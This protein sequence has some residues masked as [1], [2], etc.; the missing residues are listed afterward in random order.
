MCSGGVGSGQVLGPATTRVGSVRRV[1]CHCQLTPLSTQEPNSIHTRKPYQQMPT[2]SGGYVGQHQPGPLLVGRPYHDQRPLALDRARAR[3]HPTAHPVTAWGRHEL[4]GRE[5]SLAQGV[6]A[7]RVA[8]TPS[9][10]SASRECASTSVDST[11]PDLPGPPPALSGAPP[12]PAA[13]AAARCTA[14]GR[15]AGWRATRARRLEW[16]CCCASPP[17]PTAW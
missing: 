14:S 10:A 8:R 3:G 7:D 9:D 1:C 15:R 16:H 6:K 4:A 5:A 12:A 17:R 2:R 11:S 13:V